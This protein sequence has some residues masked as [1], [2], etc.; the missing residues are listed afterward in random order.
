MIILRILLKCRPGMDDGWLVVRKSEAGSFR[1]YVVSASERCSLPPTVPRHS[2]S[3]DEWPQGQCRMEM[4]NGFNRTK[5]H[6]FCVT[7]LLYGSTKEATVA[8]NRKL[9]AVAQISPG[10][11]CR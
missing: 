10:G 4:Q 7:L 8:S 3:Q 5:T 2:S 11:V 9:Q 1:K 6:V